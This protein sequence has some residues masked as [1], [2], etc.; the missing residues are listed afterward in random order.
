MAD[1]Y[2]VLTIADYSREKSNMKVYN[3]AITALSLPGFLTDLAALEAATQALILGTH[4][5]TM[6]VGDKTQLASTFPTDPDAQRERK[7]LVVYEGNTTHDVF[8]LTIPAVRTKTGAG[9]TL[10]NAGSD[11]FNLAHA[12]VSPWVTAFQTIGR[13]PNND[14]ENVTVISMRL[15]GRNI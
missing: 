12:L 3:G 4:Q 14:A 6:W 13:S 2:S 7:A 15:V 9:A 1:H 11:E 5:D 8:T 10:L